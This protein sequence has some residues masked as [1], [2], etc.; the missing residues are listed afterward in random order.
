MS[1][2]WV[3]KGVWVDLESLSAVGWGVLPFAPSHLERAGSLRK[4]L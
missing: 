4:S 2:W 1:V 3:D